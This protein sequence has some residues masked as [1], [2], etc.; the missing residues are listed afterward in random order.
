[1]GGDAVDS[2]GFC[3]QVAGLPEQL[4]AAHETAGSHLGPGP[5]PDPGRI[6]AVLVAGLGG[7]GIAGDVLAAVGQ[8]S[9][10]VPVV[11]A[12]QLRLP[13]WV[14]P[15]TPVFACSYSGETEETLTLAAAAVEAGAPLVAVSSGGALQALAADAGALH[16]P[17]PPGLMPRA[18]LGA[19]VAPLLVV[20]HR[21]GLLPDAHAL[22]VSAQEQLAR[23]RDACVPAVAGPVNPARDLAA[24]IGERVPVVHGTGSLG[25]VAAYRWKCD[26]NENA[27]APA[28]WAAHPELDHN[29]V[30]GFERFPVALRQACVLV[31]L[32]HGYEDPRLGPRVAATRELAAGAVAEVLTVEAAGEGRLAQLLDLMYLGDWTSCYLALDHG[33]DPGPIEAIARL[34][35]RVGG[36]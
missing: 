28:I 11:V 36:S 14:G 23:R 17:C 4:A 24:R 10:R 8:R 26:V 22:L 32:R 18:A 13:A 34:K 6:T 27:K 31:E 12:R 15:S 19:L 21:L 16:L 35:A 7:S 33:V 25:A 2:L 30:C 20:C 3:D 1:V 5:L 9:M 29:E